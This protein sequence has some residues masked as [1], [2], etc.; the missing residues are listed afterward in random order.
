MHDNANKKRIK[1]VDTRKINRLVIKITSIIIQILLVIGLIIVLIYTVTET[2]Q[3]FE[4]GLEEVAAIILENSL[5]I[6]VFLEVYLSVVD[7]FQGK[8]RSVIYV[9][10]ATLSFILREII[11]GILTGAINDTD[12]L[13]M[14]GAIGI[15][16]SGRFLLT[17]RKLIRGGKTNKER[18][19]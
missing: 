1:N 9:I 8:G 3:T 11:I 7:F 14:S 2:I 16:A 18:R 17:N 6:I 12:L 13:A 10:D 4:L 15:I 5:L 19:K